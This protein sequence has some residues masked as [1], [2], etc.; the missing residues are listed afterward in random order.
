MAYS[1][2]IW[3]DGPSP[4][5]GPAT[6]VT[7]ARL[8]AIEQALALATSSAAVIVATGEEPR[9][10]DATVVM[11]VSPDGVW[12]EN[13]AATDIVHIPDDVPPPDT[14]APSVPTGLAASA[15]TTTGFTLSWSPSTDDVGVTGY[16]V[17]LDGGTPTAA[18]SPHPFTGLTADTSY[19]AQVRARDAAGNWSAW[20]S[21]LPVSTDSEGGDGTPQ[22]SIYGATSPGTA[23]VDTNGTPI[24]TAAS[25]YRLNTPTSTNGWRVI[26]GRVWV[27][28][29][30]VGSLPGSVTIRLY[31]GG[32]GAV[33]DMNSATPLQ[34]KTTL[35][36][37]GWTTALFDTPYAPAVGG[38]ERIWIAVDF[39]TDQF[40][41]VPSTGGVMSISAADGSPVKFADASEASMGRSAWATSGSIGQSPQ[42]YGIDSL[43]DEGS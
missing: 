43:W 30:A 23:S 5:P 11:W 8:N 14:T 26:G 21:S 17:R 40:I 18:T 9:P 13:A 38:T 3:R 27:P 41:S 4:S 16:E 6:P 32:Y 10:A 7:A 31:A 29:G 34:T 28:A 15:I 1:A 36:V 35:V 25:F 20:S 24:R 37:A 39:G 12:P 22:H 42:T 2:F 33:L 19:A